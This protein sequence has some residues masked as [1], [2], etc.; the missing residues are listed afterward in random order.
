[1]IITSIFEEYLNSRHNHRFVIRTERHEKVCNNLLDIG[2]SLAHKRHDIEINFKVDSDLTEE[3]LCYEDMIPLNVKLDIVDKY[4]R[5]GDKIENSIEFIV[6]LKPLFQSTHHF[7]DMTVFW[8][9][10][11]FD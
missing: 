6:Y 8:P 1:M 3:I 4:Y 9:K 11:S 5:I 7:I 10:R 2:I